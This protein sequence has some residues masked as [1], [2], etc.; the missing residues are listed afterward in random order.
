LA[1]DGVAQRG[2]VLL[3][4]LVWGRGVRVEKHITVGDRFEAVVLVYNPAR[5]VLRVGCKQ[6]TP[7]PW[8]VHREALR[9]GHVLRALNTVLVFSSENPRRP[10]SMAVPARTRRQH[11][12][13]DHPVRRPGLQNL[14]GESSPFASH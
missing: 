3:P 8:V 13:A 6:L 1:A 11:R 2:L 12:R 7:D 4:D 9:E 14:Q 10:G 5:G